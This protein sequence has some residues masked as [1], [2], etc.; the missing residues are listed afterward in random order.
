MYI[1]AA[2]NTRVQEY[3]QPKSINMD[4]NNFLN[5]VCIFLIGFWSKIND[6]NLNSF[7]FFYFFNLLLQNVCR[8]FTCMNVCRLHVCLVLL[9]DRKGIRYSGS[10][11]RGGSEPLC[12]CC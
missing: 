5:V 6:L 3:N 9:K 10:G 1:Y 11:V 12:R 8:S 7:L 2:L 4:T